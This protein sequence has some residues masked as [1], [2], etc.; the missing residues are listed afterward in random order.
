MQVQ[1]QYRPSFAQAL[2]HLAPGE[3]IRAESGAMVGMTPNVHLDAKMQGGLLSALGRSMFAGES[4]FQ[5]TYT[6][7]GGPG[8]LLL[9]PSTPGDV[10]VVEKI[11]NEGR[12][13]RDH[14]DG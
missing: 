3:Q 5:S 1:V 8:E 14:G 6:S 9:A 7:E 12:E 13:R 2:V 4:M 10:M 11:A